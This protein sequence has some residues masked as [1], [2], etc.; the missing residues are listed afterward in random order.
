M[1]NNITSTD[2]VRNWSLC[3]KQNGQCTAPSNGLIL[4]TQNINTDGK[5]ADDH[6]DFTNSSNIRP[7]KAGKITCQ[8]AVYGGNGIGGSTN[9]I[10]YYS[11]G[12]G[13]IGSVA[14]LGTIEP[15][16]FATYDDCDNTLFYIIFAIVILIAWLLLG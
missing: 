2:S 1:G 16:S 9:N 14:T 5:V 6:G 13:A 15:F 8:D 3:A 4:Y 7:V 11:N 10:C 12:Y